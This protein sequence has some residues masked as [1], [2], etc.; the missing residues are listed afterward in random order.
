[1]SE[2]P[3]QV[4][5]MMKSAQSV[6]LLMLL[7][8][9]SGTQGLG[10]RGDVQETRALQLGSEAEEASVKE[11][12]DAEDTELKGSLMSLIRSQIADQRRTEQVAFGA[13]LPP[14]GNQGPYNI[15]ITLVYSRVLVNAGNAYNPATGIFTAP[16]KGVYY[17][18]FSGY[19][20]STKPMGLRLMKNGQQMLRLYNHPPGSRYVTATNGMNLQLKKGD[21][22]YLRLGAGTWTY[23]DS[24]YQNTF[25]GHLLFPL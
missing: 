1:M 2:N 24:N 11:R 8:S 20:Y 17:F 13:S 5:T 14:R 23:T 7:C 19:H 12:R 10:E 6:L 4:S 15:E 18:S 9:L 16:V 25:I 21:Q 3:S 22:V